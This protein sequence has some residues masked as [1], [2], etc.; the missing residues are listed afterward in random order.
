[1][2]ESLKQLK[3]LHGALFVG[4]LLLVGVGFILHNVLDIGAAISVLPEQA[5]YLIIVI[6]GG[7][8]YASDFVFRKQLATIDSETSLENR[9]DSYRQAGIIRAAL[10][11]SA[12]L[13]TGMGYILTGAHI[14]LLLCMAPIALFIY[15]F[16]KYENMVDDLNLSYAEQ[17]R[18]SISPH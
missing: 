5:L 2:K 3:L 13:C 1:M 16:P 10:I 17:N 12:A 8:L 7:S 4:I 6:A 14:Y 11:E 9:L 15:T 18:L